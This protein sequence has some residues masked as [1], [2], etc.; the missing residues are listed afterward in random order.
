MIQW[1]I[2]AVYVLAMFLFAGQEASSASQTGRWLAKLLPHLSGAE[3]RELVFAARKI[4]HVLAYG[5]LT[6]LVYYAARKTKR[7]SRL[8]LPFSVAFS[9]VV[10]LADETYQ[11]RLYYRTGTLNDV[12]I[13]G[14]GIGAAVLGVWLT[15]RFRG[16][17]K[18]VAEDVEDER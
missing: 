5:L 15:A 16:D 12:L 4:G 6:L 17:S 13:D 2:V 7:L 18:E 8:A 3:L 9:L 11:S 10:A 14:L 1:A